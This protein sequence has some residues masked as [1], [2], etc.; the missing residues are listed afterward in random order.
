MDV[1]RLADLEERVGQVNSFVSCINV[2]TIG[3]AL[4]IISPKT[5]TERSY[6]LIRFVKVF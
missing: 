3:C 2:C 6:E 1:A 4:Y 5:S